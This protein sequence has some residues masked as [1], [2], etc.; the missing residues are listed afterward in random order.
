[1]GPFSVGAHHRGA[2]VLEGLPSDAVATR[3]PY[4]RLFTVRCRLL[5]TCGGVPSTKAVRFVR[6]VRSGAVRCGPVRS[7][8]PGFVPSSLADVFR[9]RLGGGLPAQEGTAS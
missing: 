8:G 3:H 7:G 9:L 4:L 2:A 5:S 1:M 6:P